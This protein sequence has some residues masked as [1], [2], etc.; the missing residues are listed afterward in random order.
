[1]KTAV[2]EGVIPPRMAAARAEAAKH[3]CAIEALVAPGGA[4]GV[5]QCLYKAEGAAA[6][7]EEEAKK[8][9]WT[10]RS[11]LPNLLDH[12]RC[13]AAMR[14][15]LDAFEPRLAAIEARLPK[16]TDAE[17]A[18]MQDEAMALQNEVFMGGGNF[19]GMPGMVIRA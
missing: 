5:V 6:A 11:S 2:T 9:A 8:R 18:A 4:L 14:S 7:A 10:A 15:R 12:I 1:M 3:G 19:M 13:E 17:V 16:A